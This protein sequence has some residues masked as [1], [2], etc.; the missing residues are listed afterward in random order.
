MIVLSSAMKDSARVNCGPCLSSLFL[1]SFA[2]RDQ[3]SDRANI[4]GNKINCLIIVSCS[5]IMKC[6]ARIVS[7]ISR[8]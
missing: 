6:S 7:S 3:F 2:D 5:L 1:V 4:S 8:S